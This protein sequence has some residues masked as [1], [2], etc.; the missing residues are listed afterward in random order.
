MYFLKKTFAFF[1]FM[2]VTDQNDFKSNRNNRQLKITGKREA[3][4]HKKIIS[5]KSIWFFWHQH[6]L[7]KNVREIFSSNYLPEQQQ[8][9]RLENI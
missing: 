6:R 4:E 7:H 9:K 1:V 3:N 8:V 2:L 5:A